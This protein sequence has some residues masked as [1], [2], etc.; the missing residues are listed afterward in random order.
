MDFFHLNEIVLNNVA[1]V[2]NRMNLIFT[3]HEA[4]LVK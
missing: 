3:E 2:D 4:I 1:L